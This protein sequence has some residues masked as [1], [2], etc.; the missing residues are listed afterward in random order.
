MKTGPAKRVCCAIYTR[1]STD[2]GL[3]QDFNSLDAQYDASQAY[4]RSQA[5]AG[6]TLLRAK[7]D[8]GGF[9]GGNT[10]RPALQRLLEDVR[11]GKVDVIVVYKVD[12]LTRSLADFAKLV[13][14]FDAH[15]VSFVSV[16]QQFNTTTSMGRLTLNVL[17]SF[18]QFEREVTSER[19]RDKIAASKR[20]GL[21]VGGMAPLG[22]DTKDRKIS[23]NEAEAEQVRSIFAS[24]LRLG[25]L[26]LLMAELRKQGIVTKVRTLKTGEGGGHPV[27][28]G[29]ARLSTSQPLLYRRGRLQG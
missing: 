19:I 14:L 27:H 17:L 10:D 18:A 26:N 16:T 5:H 28:A 29:T 23:V 12:R 25:S 20:K 7:Y 2:Q 1:V 9:S 21:W 8:D 3:E 4:I 22:Y 11:A 13:E 15:N 24:Y 6:W